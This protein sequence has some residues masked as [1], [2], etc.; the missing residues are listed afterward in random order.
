V[1]AGG[2]SVKISISSYLLFGDSDDRM[3]IKDCELYDL[4]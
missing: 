1:H 2:V 4:A 3:I